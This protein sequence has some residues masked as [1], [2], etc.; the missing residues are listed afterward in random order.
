MQSL[1]KIFSACFALSLFVAASA[2][3][4]SA[5]GWLNWRGPNQN[6]VS[7]ETGLPDSITTDGQQTLWTYDLFGRG[8]AV[9]ANGRVY[10]LGYNA[11]GRTPDLQEVLICLEAA[12]GKRL[13]QHEFNDFLSDI[14]YDRYSI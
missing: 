12:S 11:E 10:A 2:W 4:E 9:I 6:G 7:D 1:H 8:E 3:A 13:W 5:S 14:V